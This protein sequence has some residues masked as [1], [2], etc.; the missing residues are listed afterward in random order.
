[1]TMHQRHG[2]NGRRTARVRL[3]LALLPVLPL[4]GC[5]GVGTPGDPNGEWTGTL[6]TD[7]GT[8]PDH[9]LSRLLVDGRDISF[10]PTAGVLVLHGRRPAD[11]P[12]LHAQLVLTDMNKKPLPMVFEGRLSTDGSRI[13]GTY[14]TPSCRAHVVLVR[15]VNHPLDRAFGN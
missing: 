10:I 12:R 9:A 13:D 3:L 8:C 7:K 14:G 5:G 4:A 15:P 2:S 11:D 1:M 6:I